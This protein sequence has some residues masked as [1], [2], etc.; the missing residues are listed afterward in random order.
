M[1][2]PATQARRVRV[3]LIPAWA[4][5]EE[6]GL[7]LE[8]ELELEPARCRECRSLG[9]LCRTRTRRS[10]CSSILDEGATKCRLRWRRPLSRDDWMWVQL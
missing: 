6:L 1:Q 2:T 7:G 9:P 8:M 10:R 3:M 5:V 4:V